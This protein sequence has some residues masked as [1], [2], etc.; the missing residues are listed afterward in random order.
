MP[1]QQSRPHS[2]SPAGRCLLAFIGLSTAAIGAVFVWLL[3]Q[4]YLNA[5]A[6][7]AWPQAPCT[8][9][10][11]TVEERQH[12]PFSPFEYRHSILFGFEFQ[13]KN[14]TST[15]LSL[16]GNPWSKNRTD[17][18]KRMK[19]LPQGTRT[20]CFISPTAPHIAVLKTDSLAPGYSIWF[21]SLFV[22][23]GLVMAVRAIK[24][25]SIAA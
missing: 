10:L 25:R 7:R 12:D 6:M 19:A 24:P 13:G 22:L 21:P 14:H 8:I 23:G 9:L 5:K 4:S 1:L 2:P 3:G 15:L 11:S 17:V 16:R 18:E 20:S